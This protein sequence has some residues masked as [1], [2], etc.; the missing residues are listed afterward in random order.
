M[1]EKLRTY[2]GRVNA[3]KRHRPPDDPEIADAERDLRAASLADHIRRVVA[4]APPLTPAQR[5]RPALLL[6]PGTGGGA[7]G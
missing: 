2:S 7:D 4:A 3:L 5:E 6:H 1:P